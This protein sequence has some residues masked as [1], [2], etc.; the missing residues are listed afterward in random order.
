MEPEPP[1]SDDM[2]LRDAGI[3]E[4]PRTPLAGMELEPVP[5]APDDAPMPGTSVGGVWE[6]LLVGGEEPDEGGRGS[7]PLVGLEVLL[8]VAMAEEEGEVAAEMTVTAV[9]AACCNCTC[10][11]MAEL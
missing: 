2:P 10:P 7:R 8:L 6:V 9:L 4:R 1:S 3:P 11:C 5:P